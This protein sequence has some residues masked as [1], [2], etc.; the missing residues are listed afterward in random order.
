M[1]KCATTP[2]YTIGLPLLVHLLSLLLLL[3]LFTQMSFF[4]RTSV[5]V[6]L[7]HILNP[8]WDWITEKRAKLLLIGRPIWITKLSLFITHIIHIYVWI[9]GVLLS[10]ICMFLKISNILTINSRGLP[11][12]L[13]V[14]IFIH[15]F[16]T[17]IISLALILATW[18]LA[19]FQRHSIRASFPYLYIY[20]TFNQQL[21]STYYMPGSIIN[22]KYI[23]WSLP[24]RTL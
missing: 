13:K 17:E 10:K 16:L 9:L 11:L 20:S 14:S 18:S 1:L 19:Y 23:M 6:A 22:M 12:F 2:V 15:P 24:L 5:I 8:I 7:E 4:K 21:L 3:I